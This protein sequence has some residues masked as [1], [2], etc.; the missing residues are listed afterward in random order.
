MKSQATF[1][2]PNDN[3][4]AKHTINLY[5]EGGFELKAKIKEMQS[6]GLHGI[7]VVDC[8]EEE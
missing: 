5:T 4:T 8:S 1:T 2:T 3:H 7:T 6:H